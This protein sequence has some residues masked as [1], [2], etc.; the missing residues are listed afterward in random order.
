MTPNGEHCDR[1]LNATGKPSRVQGGSNPEVG[2]S[3]SA[4][5]VEIAD[6]NRQRVYSAPVNGRSPN[7]PSVVQVAIP[8]LSPLVSLYY[9]IKL[10]CVDRYLPGR[11]SLQSN[12]AAQSQSKLHMKLRPGRSAPHRHTRGRSSARLA[13]SGQ[14]RQN[15]FTGSASSPSMRV[16]RTRTG[17]NRLNSS[18]LG[19]GLPAPY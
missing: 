2:A 4:K 17:K 15:P 12:T 3:D 1:I 19:F 9:R 7:S 18:T 5:R 11:V 13:Q 16:S 6:A 10:F 8:V 14:R